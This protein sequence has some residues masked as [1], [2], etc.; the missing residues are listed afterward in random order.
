MEASLQAL[1][2][3]VS[4]RYPGFP[5]EEAEYETIMQ[6]RIMR[7]IMM[8]TMMMMTATVTQSALV[9]ILDLAKTAPDDQK[10]DEVSLLLAIKVYLM[11][12]PVTSLASPNIKYELFFK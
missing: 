11:R 7:M 1:E 10:I 4:I 6:V 2:T 3:L 12:G 8:I 5:K 9:R